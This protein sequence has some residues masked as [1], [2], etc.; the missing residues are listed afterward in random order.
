MKTKRKIVKALS[1]VFIVFVIMSVAVTSVSATDDSRNNAI[2]AAQYR[3]NFTYSLAT[4]SDD[5]L[6]RWNTSWFDDNQDYTIPNRQ[7]QFYLQTFRPA[8]EDWN[9]R[10]GTLINN[11]NSLTDDSIFNSFRTKLDNVYREYSSALEAGNSYLLHNVNYETIQQNNSNIE[12]CTTNLD[13]AKTNF[14]ALIEEVE[15][16]KRQSDATNSVNNTT[17]DLFNIPQAL[18]S[19][20]G[21]SISD[22]ASNASVFGLS[23][24]TVETV[25]NNLS[26][27]I[28][29]LAYLVLI[30]SFATSAS[31]S[32]MRFELTTPRGAMRVFIQVALGKASIDLSVM[33]CMAIVK[34][35]NSIASGA[36]LV[37]ANMGSFRGT[38][39]TDVLTGSGRY[40]LSVTSGNPL[41]IFSFLFSIIPKLVICVVIITTLCKVIMKLVMRNFE[42]GCLITIAPLGFA[43]LAG[44]STKR[45]FMKYLGALIGSAMTI[46]FIAITYNIVS[47]WL[48]NI[49]TNNTSVLFVSSEWVTMI[50]LCA[51]ARFIWKPPATLTNLF[52]FM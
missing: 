43:T 12:S 26:P 4:P 5:T 34:L 16:T 19:L 52:T 30:V 51:M 6:Y 42:L 48:H 7:Y 38:D 31:E 27:Y 39:L 37:S 32:A 25:T 44:E 18:W 13:T 23:L 35:I 20:L 49:V 1:V 40:I 14:N 41:A 9:N 33:L 47:V 50:I 46:L 11:I 28:T 24:S 21:N 17:D 36:I 8:S 22:T 10:S 15:A 45:F 29:V 2:D 3:M